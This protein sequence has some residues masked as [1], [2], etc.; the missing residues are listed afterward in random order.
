MSVVLEIGG[1]FETSGLAESAALP[2]CPRNGPFAAQPGSTR[3]GPASGRNAP[4][5]AQPGRGLSR[6]RR[7][8]MDGSPNAADNRV[9]TVVVFA[10]RADLGTTNLPVDCEESLPIGAV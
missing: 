5:H 4:R 9:R 8:P 2:K 7:I 6:I 3:P 10:R 1:H